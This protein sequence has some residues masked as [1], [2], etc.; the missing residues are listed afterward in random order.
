MELPSEIRFVDENVRKA[1]QKLKEGDNSEKE[2]YEFINQALDNL[3]K[4]AFCGIQIPRRLIPK[5]YKK[6]YNVGNLWK[7]NL[8]NAWRLIYHIKGSK[9]LVIS[10]VL[11]WMDHKDYNRKFKY[12]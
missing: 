4:N 12:K 10:V 5:R 3:E 7:Y 9:A 6:K 8:P 11:S 2:L 1:F